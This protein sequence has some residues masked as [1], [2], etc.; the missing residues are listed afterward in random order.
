MSDSGKTEEERRKELVAQL[1]TAATALYD[2]WNTF[3]DVARS[4]D[5]DI[6]YFA[7]RVGSA[8]YS[9]YAKSAEVLKNARI[10]D[11]LCGASETHS[12]VRR[13]MHCAG[14]GLSDSNVGVFLSDMDTL[15]EVERRMFKGFS[16]G[17]RVELTETFKVFRPEDFVPVD[18][19][20]KGTQGTLTEFLTKDMCVVALD[21]PTS[22]ET[23]EGKPLPRV[24]IGLDK[25]RRIP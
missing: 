24:M 5:S 18:G 21:V 12:R 16:V 1:E 10:W 22:N 4:E 17:D 3:N 15:Q 7:E 23:A 25:L 2:C 6:K 19:P 13:L 11:L 9:V 14:D 8:L 20:P